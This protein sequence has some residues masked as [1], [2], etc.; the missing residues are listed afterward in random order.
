VTGAHG[1][2]A[3]AAASRLLSRARRTRKFAALHLPVRHAG[4]LLVPL[5]RDEIF[6]DLARGRGFESTELTFVTNVLQPDGVFWDLGANF[7]LYA[8]SAARTVGRRGHVL[9]VEP[10]PRNV[11]RLRTNLVLNRCRNVET[12]AAAVGE[13]EGVIDF[14]SCD[15]GAYSGVRLGDHPGT[16]TTISVPQTTLDAL[17]SEPGRLPPD[18]VKMDIEGSELFALR[19]GADLFERVR[20]MLLAEFSDRR[21]SPH[22]YAAADLYDWLTERDYGLFRF[23]SPSR[24]VPDGR[25]ASY[26]ADNL[27]ACPREAVD[28]LSRWLDAE[29]RSV[30]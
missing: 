20:P 29:S 13:S 17:S 5:P 4:A 3:R 28:R 24:L 1:G 19:G 14:E 21:T 2:A 7:G 6:A 11:R 12:I 27:V 16:N 25:R 9:A 26:D 23:V 22:G 18:V 15:Q 30:E 10:D 8:I